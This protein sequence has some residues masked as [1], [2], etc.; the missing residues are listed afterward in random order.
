MCDALVTAIRHSMWNIMVTTMRP[1]VWDTLVTL[2]RLIVWCFGD[3]TSFEDVG[4]FGW[5]WRSP[6]VW[7]LSQGVG[8]W[9][10]HRCMA[11]MYYQDIHSNV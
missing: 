1:H 5:L 3:R 8:C 4:V 10:C 11:G 2:V 7:M 9:G 6:G